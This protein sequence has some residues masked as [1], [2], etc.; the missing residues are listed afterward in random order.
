MITKN[1][2]YGIVILTILIACNKTDPCALVFQNNEPSFLLLNIIDGQT[3]QNILLGD[4]ATINI[5]NLEITG[6]SNG[7]SIEL[8]SFPEMIE[9]D[10]VLIVSLVNSDQFL[11]FAD[12]IVIQYN[13]LYPPDTLGIDYAVNSYCGDTPFIYQYNVHS[14]NEYLCK[15]CFSE[16]ITILK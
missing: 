13:N 14:K 12:A 15:L 5:D 4:E 2:F 10:S 1:R 16:S 3:G 8:V 7:E 9:G 11:D 6:I